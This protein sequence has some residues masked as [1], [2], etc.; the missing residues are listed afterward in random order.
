[1]RVLDEEG[2]MLGVFSRQ[3]ALNKAREMGTDLVE[4]A[5][6]A[7]PPVAKII[8]FNKYLYQLAKRDKGEKKGKAEI[9][10]VKISLFAAENDLARL[11]RRAGEF[12]KEGHQ[13]RVS[14]RLKG[15]EMG[16]QEQARAVL[17][18]FTGRV[19]KAKLVS[20]PSLI[21]R[22]L[23]AVISLDKGT[24]EKKQTEN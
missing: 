21:G 2:N 5:P 13:V 12:L 7:M 23:R 9:K 14:L 3:E 4:I 16:K 17:M 11:A 10:E 6:S 15:R 8:D 24:H 20:T 22:D 19:E 1:M 18:L